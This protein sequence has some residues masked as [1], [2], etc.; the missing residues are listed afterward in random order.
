MVSEYKVAHEN[1]QDVA[2]RMKQSLSA[3]SAEV[4]GKF[5]Q[6][7]GS[8]QVFGMPDGWTQHVDPDS[9]TDIQ[10]HTLSTLSCVRCTK[11]NMTFIGFSQLQVHRLMTELDGGH[12]E[13]YSLRHFFEEEMYDAL[14]AIILKR[15]FVLVDWVTMF[16]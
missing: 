11:C 13:Q 10:L 1:F 15:T 14:S 9:V 5:D 12:G 8:I 6:V 3:S 4:Y 16:C 7:L 2:V